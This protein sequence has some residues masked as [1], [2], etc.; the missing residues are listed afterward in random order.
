MHLKLRRGRVPTTFNVYLDDAFRR[1]RPVAGKGWRETSERLDMKIWNILGAFV[2]M[3]LLAT[4]ANAITNAAKC[5]AKKSV[6]AGKEFYACM[7]CTTKQYGD[8]TY[9]YAGCIAKAQGKCEAAFAKADLAY[10]VDCNVIGNGPTVCSDTLLSC[11]S[12]W[13]AIRP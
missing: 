2:V 13:G 6:A 7:K 8:F 11:D 4:S 12:I 10:P 9:D 3:A 5:D 1:T